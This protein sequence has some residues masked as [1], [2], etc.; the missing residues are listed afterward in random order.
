[1]FS[2]VLISYPILIQKDVILLYVDGVV[3][4]HQ[5][6]L[7]SDLTEVFTQR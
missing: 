7:A 4:Q 3:K 5:L 2:A 6:Q 1:M